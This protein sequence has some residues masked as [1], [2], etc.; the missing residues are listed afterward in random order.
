MTGAL[1]F[2]TFGELL[3]LEDSGAYKET[4]ADV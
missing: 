1:A 2:D 4:A 3:P